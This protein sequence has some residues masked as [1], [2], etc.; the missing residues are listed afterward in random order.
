MKEKL[1]AREFKE[2]IRRLLRRDFEGNTGMALKNSIFQ[3]STNIVAKIGALFFTIILARLLLPELFGLYSLALSTI[4]IFA[5]LAELGIGQTLIRFVSKELGKNKKETKAKSYVIHLGK[6]RLIL[7]FISMLILVIFSKFIANT[8]YQKPIFLALIAGSLYILFVGIVG[9]LQSILMASNYFRGILYKEIIFQIVRLFIVPLLILFSLKQLLSNEYVLFFIIIGLSFSYFI[10]SIVLLIL[11]RSKLKYL[12]EKEKKISSSE[13]KKVNKFILPVSAT[14][15]TAIFFG[16]IDIVMLG[17]F[18]LSEYIGYYRA[19]LGLVA[20]AAPLIIFSSALLP[21]FSR[22][23]NQQLERG[24]KKSLS[25]TILISLALFFF[26]FLF[27]PFIINFV[28]GERYGP[29][30]NLLRLFSLL[31]LNSPITSIYGSYFTAKGK[32]IIVTRTLVVSLVV[33]II[34]NLLA[35]L[36]FLDRGDLFVVYGVAGA[37]IISSWFYTAGL[38]WSKNRE[39]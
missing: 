33:N 6:L 3:L 13:K 16:Y 9:F 21:I 34:L 5:T 38:M 25:V 4:I 29:S 17:R 11:S 30:I 1:G 28:Y 7:I 35:I 10:S 27:S 15:I 12:K 8:Y 31:F 18:V 24:F 14:V 22:L 20:A 23:K 26:V 37:T 2:I 32:P 36:F 39:K 19:A